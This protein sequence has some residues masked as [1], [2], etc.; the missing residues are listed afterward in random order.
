MKPLLFILI[1]LTSLGCFGQQGAGK[2]IADKKSGCKVWVATGY[3]ATDSLSITWDGDCKNKIAEGYGT[4][5]WYVK[6]KEVSRYVGFMQKGNPNGQGKYDYGGGVTGEGNFKNGVLHGVGKVTFGNGNKLEGNFFEG[7]IL[8]LEDRYLMELEKIVISKDDS[9]DMYINDNN[10]KELFYHAL[11]PKSVVKGVLVLLPGTWERTEYVLSSNKQ[12]AQLAF[13]QGIAVIVPSIN[14]RLVLNTDVLHFLNSVFKDGIEK[15]KL[16]KEKFVLG[17]FSM[18][19]L[20]SIR[21][22]ELAYENK[23]ATTVV[24]KAVYSVDG[25]ADLE[26]IYKLFQRGIEKNPTAAEPKYGINEFQKYIGGTP[27]QFRKKYVYYS[28]FSKSEKDGGNAKYL[29][30]VPIRIYNDVDVAWWIENRGNDLYDMNALDQSALINFLNKIGNKNAEF[31]N[32]YG[33]GYRLEGRR[34][35]H[36]W[37]IVDAAECLKWINKHI[38]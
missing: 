2:F 36:S 38:Q 7:E 12:L 16:P 21:Y 34:H 20:F 30:N 22:T 24:P 8:N 15:Y 23:A 5:I 4:L 17:G 32:A 27:D 28:S 10:A 25:P 3:S 35:P 9:T 1:S 13:D 11:V 26:N 6:E 19:G 18:G 31:I 29:N 14:Q 37:S 33:K